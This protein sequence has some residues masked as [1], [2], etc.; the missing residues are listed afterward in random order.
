[1]GVES[2]KSEINLSRSDSDSS[3]NSGLNNGEFEK[4][5]CGDEN[6]NTIIYR[7]WIAKKT[8]TLTDDNVRVLPPNPFDSSILLWLNHETNG[9]IK[10]FLP[11][12]DIFLIK[13]GIKPYAKHWA[14]ILELSNETYVNIQ[15]GRNGFSL[16]EFNKTNIEGESILNAILDT[17]GEEGHPFS[18]CY[19][20][21]ANCKYEELLNYLKEVKIKESKIYL[22]NDSTYYNLAF[23]NCQHFACYI[24]SFL[25]GNIYF[26]HS[27][28][29]Y[30]DKF[31]EVFFPNVDI[32]KLRAKYQNDLI[33]KNRE[34]FK[35]DIEQLISNSDEVKEILKSKK[36]YINPDEIIKCAMRELQNIFSLNAEDYVKKITIQRKDTNLL[37]CKKNL[38]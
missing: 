30:L 11:K 24:E 32:I 21:I 27:F 6:K 9:C 8:I 20:G 1:M 25:R 2:S 22:E 26:W 3:S 36:I 28:D 17:W 38:K 37:V 34:L 15:F 16:K 12:Q 35:Y 19:L 14:T 7:V 5:K 23:F 13:N 4:M 18:F 10:L 31:Y 29:Y 33:A